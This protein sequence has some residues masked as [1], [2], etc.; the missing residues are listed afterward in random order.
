M[1]LPGTG[2]TNVV[3]TFRPMSSADRFT[4]SSARSSILDVPAAG[5]APGS[6]ALM[7]NYPNPFNPSTTIRYTVP[8]DLER[9]AARCTTSWDRK[10]GTLASGLASARHVPCA[11]RC[12]R[13]GERDVLLC[14]G[15]GREE[16]GGEDDGIE[17][18]EEGRRKKEEREA[19]DEAQSVR[20]ADTEKG[21]RDAF[22]LPSSFFLL[23]CFTVLPPARSTARSSACRSPRSRSPV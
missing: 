10:C 21:R 14:V 3:L 12:A 16:G 18:E 15:G 7:Q 5:S 8:V 11:V 22:L 4:F 6:F 9:H 1:I 23:L 13:V 17:V 20:S 2:D 19:R